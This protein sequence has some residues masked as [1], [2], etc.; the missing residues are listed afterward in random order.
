MT[1]ACVVQPDEGKSYWQPLPANGHVELKVARNDGA[2]RFDCGVQEVAPGCFVREHAHDAH[3]ELIF[4][5]E[6]TGEALVGGEGHPLRPG[7]TL[8]LDA[9]RTH[10]FVN[11]GDGPLRFF[12]VLMPGG[13]SE[14]FKAI[15]PERHPGEA[16]PAPFPRP[17]NIAEIEQQTVFAKRAP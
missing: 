11:T 15:G 10:K 13:L 16:P 9:E 8:Y 6:G 1:K 4:V 7:T 2:A 5:Y 17:A 3:E 14:F 12:W